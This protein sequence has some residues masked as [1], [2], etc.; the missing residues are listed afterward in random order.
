MSKSNKKTLVYGDY[1]LIAIEEKKKYW[2]IYICSRNTHVEY[3]LNR[4]VVTG[5][6]SCKKA[7]EKAK[8]HISR[9][10]W[11]LFARNDD[12]E[13]YIH[14]N[15]DGNYEYKIVS[16]NAELIVPVSDTETAKGD[17]AMHIENYKWKFAQETSSLSIYTRQNPLSSKWEYRIE[18]DEERINCKNDFKSP[19]EAIENALL[20]ISEIDWE[21]TM[22]Y[23]VF[24][25][26]TRTNSCGLFD[27]KT[28]LD[29][30]TID[31]EVGFSDK[32]LMLITAIGRAD[33]YY[34]KLKHNHQV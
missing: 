17:I 3:A 24:Q 1:E 22:N 30:N 29:K 18:K 9:H 7:F 33:K 15:F 4:Q 19:E 26:Y 34:R 21:L 11:K 2:N 20:S 25:I 10:A 27:Y 28:S 31:E 32:Q 13:F 12:F 14:K 8:G 5:A 16:T 23:D 6:S